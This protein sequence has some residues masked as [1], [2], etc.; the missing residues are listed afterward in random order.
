MLL[1]KPRTC[2]FVGPS[3]CS[4]CLCRRELWSPT[5][6]LH[7]SRGFPGSL[8]NFVH[9]EGWLV[10]VK[11]GPWG[12]NLLHPFIHCEGCGSLVLELLLSTSKDPG[13]STTQ[14]FMH[15]LTARALA[16]EFASSDHFRRIGNP[17]A[18]YPFLVTFRCLSLVLLPPA[19]TLVVCS[20]QCRCH[21]SRQ[22]SA[23]LG[24]VSC[25]ARPTV[26]GTSTG[27]IRLLLLADGPQP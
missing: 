15:I 5:T 6:R 22:P 3:R 1:G 20:W 26:V 12:R 25:E 9:A 8:P 14:G 7:T 21:P 13:L 24:R 27:C 19:L 4:H 18:P 11:V 16:R 10:T 2:H 23:S 17:G